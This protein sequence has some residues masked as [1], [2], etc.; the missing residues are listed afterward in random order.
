MSNTPP[1]AFKP[2]PSVALPR[3]DPL[4]LRLPGR[5]PAPPTPA[6]VWAQIFALAP[7]D[8]PWMV[9]PTDGGLGGVKAAMLAAGFGFASPTQ[10]RRPPHADRRPHT[11]TNPDHHANSDADT[12]S[13]AKRIP[14]ADT[15]SHADTDSNPDATRPTPTRTPIITLTAATLPP[16]RPRQLRRRPALTDQSQPPLPDRR[17]RPARPPRPNAAPT[18][19]PIAAS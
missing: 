9:R 13:Y 2:Y 15:D 17:S 3:I 11:D 7:A 4:V 19:H 16:R 1:P 12:N 5:Q 8:L 14:D 18:A 6:A 10:R